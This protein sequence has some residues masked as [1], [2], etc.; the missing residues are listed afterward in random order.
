MYGK[1]LSELDGPIF[2]TMAPGVFELEASTLA[3]YF[4]LSPE[5]YFSQS[6]KETPKLAATQHAVWDIRLYRKSAQT[7]MG[8]CLLKAHF[9]KSQESRP[10]YGSEKNPLNIREIPFLF[11]SVVLLRM[12][13]V[14]A[15][16]GQD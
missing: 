3:S 14:S 7:V 16:N 6:I 15:L 4:F 1:R 10:P 13:A 12:S 9:I 8:W 5:F 11:R 2:N